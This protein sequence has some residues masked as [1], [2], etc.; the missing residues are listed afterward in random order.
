MGV[1]WVEELVRPAAC[2]A[3]SAS[4]VGVECKADLPVLVVPGPWDMAV[5][6]CSVR[7]VQAELRLRLLL[8]VESVEGYS[9]K[10]RNTRGAHSSVK[11][12]A[13]NLRHLL[14]S[15]GSL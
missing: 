10:A 15:E 3:A 1:L 6:H 11:F 14:C 2:F 5:C 7:L 13:V 9:T 4:F 8:Q 12:V